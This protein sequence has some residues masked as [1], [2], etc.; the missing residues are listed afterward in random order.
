VSSFLPKNTYRIQRWRWKTAVLDS[1]FT[2]HHSM[3]SPQQKSGYINPP[4]YLQL[5]LQ[6]SYHI[7]IYQ[8]HKLSVNVFFSTQKHHHQI[9]WRHGDRCSSYNTRSSQ[10]DVFTHRPPPSPLSKWHHIDVMRLWLLLSARHH[11]VRK[12]S[13]L[14]LV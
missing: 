5:S 13:T 12:R 1:K 4:L 14:H 8:K 11:Y 2:S 9:I 7:S 3:L 10:I 6:S